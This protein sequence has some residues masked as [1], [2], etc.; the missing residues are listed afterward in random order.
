M[1][2][3][4][5]V[6]QDLDCLDSEKRSSTIASH[7]I[8]LDEGIVVRLPTM[9][10]EPRGGGEVMARGGYVLA[11]QILELD[12]E[13]RKLHPL[14]ILVSMPS[15][16]TLMEAAKSL[17]KALAARHGAPTTVSWSTLFALGRSERETLVGSR[18]LI[19]EMKCPSVWQSLCGFAALWL[20]RFPVR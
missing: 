2:Y 19:P 5:S 10:P 12:A 3:G 6:A 15:V 14:S 4:E 13:E 17:Q 1:G 11:G 18:E 7:P 9:H 16:A 20:S 8:G